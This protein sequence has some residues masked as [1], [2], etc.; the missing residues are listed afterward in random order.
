[1]TEQL[2][3]AV[4]DWGALALAVILAINCVG[5]PFPSSLLMLAV[6]SLVAQGEMDLAAVLAFGV[7]GA[8]AGDQAGYFIGR[9]GG[10]PL[11]ERLARRFRAEATLARA[12]GFID[13]WGGTGV[14]FT[15]WLLSPTG[16]YVNLVSGLAPLAWIRFTVAGVAGEVVWVGLYVSLGMLFSDSVQNLAAVLGNLTWFLVGL[17]A[18]LALG[19]A[20]VRSLR[21]HGADRRPGAAR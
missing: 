1:M 18:T 19:Y 20:L 7:A 12:R 17:A 15:R 4:G 8:V 11:A 3:A 16:P 14:F 10:P 21:H 6:G 13:R 5:V 9:L 2:M